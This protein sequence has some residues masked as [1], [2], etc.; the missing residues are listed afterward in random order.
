MSLY[1]DEKSTCEMM[2]VLSIIYK[3]NTY[4]GDWLFHQKK[5]IFYLNIDKTKWIF[6]FINY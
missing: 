3:F 2:N 6:F 5:I 4:I 1:F